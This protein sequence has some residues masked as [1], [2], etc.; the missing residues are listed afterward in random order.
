M[1]HNSK[2]TTLVKIPVRRLLALPDLDE[3]NKQ[4]F[5]K[6]N[7][8]KLNRSDALTCSLALTDRKAD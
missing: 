2:A 6:K 8:N 1:K 7:K 4:R 3:K 5:R